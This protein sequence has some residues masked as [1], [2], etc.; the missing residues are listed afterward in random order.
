MRQ[1][2]PISGM[3]LLLFLCV[4]VGRAQWLDDRNP[5]LTCTDGLQ[6][7]QNDQAYHRTETALR[8]ADDWISAEASGTET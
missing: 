1:R 4:V 7:I 6:R 2:K 5:S 8:N 3:L